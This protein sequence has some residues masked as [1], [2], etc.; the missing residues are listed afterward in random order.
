MDDETKSKD[1]AIPNDRLFGGSDF[2]DA[3]AAA[4]GSAAL[5][6]CSTA[7]AP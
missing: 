5:P 1:D 4:P 2:D 3:A 7:D 6:G